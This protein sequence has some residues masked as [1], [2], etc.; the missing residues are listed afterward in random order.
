M[1]HVKVSERKEL[2]EQG[3]QIVKKGKGG[4][5]NFPTSRAGLITT[6]EDREIVRRLLK[7]TL[8]AYRMPKVKSDEELTQRLDEYFSLC[9]ETGQ[10]PTVEEMC[11]YTGYGYRGLYDIEV[12]R[13]KGF[14]DSTSHIIKKAKE[15]MQSFDAKLAVSGKMNF[16]AYCFR[17]KNYYGMTDKTEYVLTPN[18]KPESDYN[19]EDIK[20]RYLSDSATL[21]DSD[22]D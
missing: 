12:G 13:S 4:N 8:S 1:P 21:G 3:E 18:T 19:A 10:I 9:A 7:E 2:I 6:D 5:A 22:S 17:A 16:L 14:S 20:N 11:L 15:Y